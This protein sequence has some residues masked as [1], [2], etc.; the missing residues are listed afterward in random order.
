MADDP[1]PTCNGNRGWWEYGNG[2]SGSKPKQWISCRACNG[3]GKK[4]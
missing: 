4:A 1:C 2:K 3:T